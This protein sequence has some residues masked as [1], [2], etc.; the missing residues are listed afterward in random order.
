MQKVQSLALDIVKCQTL[1]IE[2]QKEYINLV[3]TF[4][5]N[6]KLQLPPFKLQRNKL[7]TL[8]TIL[9]GLYDQAGYK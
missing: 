1:L 3:E 7:Y 4:V 6:R 8:V 2:A 9:E 5:N